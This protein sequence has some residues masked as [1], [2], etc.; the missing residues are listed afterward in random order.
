MLIFKPIK[1]IFLS[2]NLENSWGGVNL[3][4]KNLTSR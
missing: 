1:R 3:Y 2:E 4:R